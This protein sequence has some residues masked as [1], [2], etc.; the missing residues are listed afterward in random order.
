M[1]GGAGSAAFQR[2]SL[3]SGGRESRTPISCLEIGLYVFMGRTRMCSIT[4]AN[5]WL[6]KL[7][8]S[9]VSRYIGVQP[10]SRI[11]L[12]HLVVNWSATH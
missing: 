3:V 4:G 9:H 5:T 10:S 1:L 2:G 8:L 6:P 11:N 12:S 7:A